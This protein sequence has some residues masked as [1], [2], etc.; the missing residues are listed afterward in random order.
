[1]LVYVVMR[2]TGSHEDMVTDAVAAYDSIEDAS[3]HAN[4]AND[5]VGSIKQKWE[6]E[7]EKNNIP[8]Y[9]FRGYLS[10]APILERVVKE[11]PM[12]YDEKQSMPYEDWLFFY[13]QEQP[14]EIISGNPGTR[15]KEQ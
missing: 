11:N 12:P 7:C 3:K 13:V 14:I 9:S 8:F 5:W 1:M 6:Q 2:E 15:R 4:T 10:K